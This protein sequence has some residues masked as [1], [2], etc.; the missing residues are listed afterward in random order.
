MKQFLFFLSTFLLFVTACTDKTNESSP[1]ISILIKT[2]KQ[3][4]P[5]DGRLLLIFANNNETEPRFQIN[6]GLKT[7]V[8]FGM[9]V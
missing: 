4:M 3:T 5:E 6:G 2:D 9:N 8:I 7:Q 1:E